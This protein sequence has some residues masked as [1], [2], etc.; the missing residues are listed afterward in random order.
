MDNSN[1]ETLLSIKDLEITFGTGNSKFVAVQDVNFDIFKGEIFSLVGESGSGKT[2]IGRAVLGINPTS[3]GQIIFEGKQIN[4]KISGKEKFDIERKIQM[5]FQDPSASLNERATVDYIISE[6][7][8]NY[9]LFKNEEDRLNKVRKMLEAVGLLPEQ[10]Y[11]YPHE[12]SG[13]QRQRIGIARA[14]IMNPDLVVADEPISALDM[15]IRAQVLN[16]LK[17][18]QREQGVTF[19]FVAHDLSVVRYISDRIAVI[20]AGRILELAE[21]EELFNNPIH[22]YTKSLLSAIPI[23]DPQIAKNREN[24]VYDPSIHNYST[25]KPKFEEIKPGHF[26]YCN[27]TEA[28]EYKIKFNK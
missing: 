24:I 17:K 18:F 19:L 14:L 3:N 23:P 27:E 28:K 21:T 16:L 7:L 9:K 11:R 1:R 15:S 20:R 10:L 5:I 2:T 13:G 6:G 12:F 26:V 22:P 25:E 8:Y 4:G